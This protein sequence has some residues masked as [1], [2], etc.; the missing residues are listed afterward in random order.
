MIQPG[1]SLQHYG[2]DPYS[3][4]KNLQL[5]SP[6]E[7]IKRFNQQRESYINHL[8]EDQVVS[9]LYQ[10]WPAENGNIFISS[11]KKARDNII[12]QI[13]FNERNGLFYN[14]ILQSVEQAIKYP[15]NLIALYS[16]TGK[17]LFNST[18]AESVPEEKSKWLNEPYDIGQLYFLYFDGNKINNVAV[19][20]NDDN[21]PW[22]M[23]LAPVFK[24]INQEPDEEKRISLFLTTPV[25]LEN[26]DHFLQ[27]DWND[28][29]HIFKNVHSEDFYLDKVINDMKEAFADKKKLKTP[30]YNDQT[31]QALY[32]PEITADVI[33]QGYF[34]AIYNFMKEKELSTTKFGGGCPGD[35][36]EMSAVEK[37]LG[38]DVMQSIVTGRNIFMQNASSLSTSYRD[39]RQHKNDE[40][41]DE[42]G[43]LKFHCPVCNGEHVR[44]RH[45]LL[46]IC[47]ARGKEIPKC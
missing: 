36:A 20:V 23:D 12:H 5:L 24:R 37:I 26:I 27:R 29:Y 19:S 45:K 15:G 25:L 35:G 4:V 42:Y 34:S 33:T 32:R 7:R 21:N 40:N 38:Y 2:F 44:P 14:G 10:Y 16:P 28:N 11:A 47:P 18:K 13:D 43:S 3:E 22:L 46:S 31:V 41:S 9:I 17:K 8:L 6:T 1:D 39:L 30:F